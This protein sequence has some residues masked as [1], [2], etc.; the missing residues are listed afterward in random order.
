[1][2]IT[3]YIPTNTFIDKR[4][5]AD[6]AQLYDFISRMGESEYNE[7]LNNIK[8]FLK[9]DGFKKFTRKSFAQ[10]LTRIITSQ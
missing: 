5:F 7:Y 6:Y 9:S 10:D 8:I 1:M 4:D 2:N 3:D